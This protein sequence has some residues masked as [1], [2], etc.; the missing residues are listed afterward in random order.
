VKSYRVREL[1]SGSI[2]VDVTENGTVVQ[3]VTGFAS[4]A[5]ARDWIE[6][7]IAAERET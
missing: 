5:E 7:Q 3:C 6:E 4:V 1:P 2:V